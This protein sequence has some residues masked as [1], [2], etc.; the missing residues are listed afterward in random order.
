MSAAAGGAASGRAWRWAGQQGRPGS[1][2]G[3]VVLMA[4]PAATPSA[5]NAEENNAR[6]DYQC[7][8]GQLGKATADGNLVGVAIDDIPGDGVGRVRL[9]CSITC[10]PN[11][12]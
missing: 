12:S 4:A 11:K 8:P 1:P 7:A 5:D 3:C 2:P 9:L 10:I 6:A